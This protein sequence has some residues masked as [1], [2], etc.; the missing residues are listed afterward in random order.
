MFSR[1]RHSSTHSHA[2]RRSR[3]NPKQNGA[4][5]LVGAI[6]ERPFLSRCPVLLSVCAAVLT[7]MVC[8]AQ[9]RS[10]NG[11]STQGN[12]GGKPPSAGI[13]VSTTP[14][15]S[16]PSAFTTERGRTAG[17]TV[18]LDS[19]PTADVTINVTSS[20]T[21]E[22]NTDV[23]AL[24][25]TPTTWNIPQ[26]VIVIGADDM[27]ADGTVGYWIETEPASSEDPDYN[28]LNAADVSRSNIDDESPVTDA[29]YVRSFEMESRKKGP[30]TE[31]RLNIDVRHD[32]DA[33]GA[34]EESDFPAAG[35]VV[36]IAIYDSNGANVRNFVGTTSAQGAGTTAWYKLPGAGDYQIE[37]HDLSLTGFYWDPLDVLESS[38]GDEDWDGRPDVLLSN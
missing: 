35:V 3:W 5:L 29:I 21:T 33:N 13:S 12:K 11:M 8:C 38:L 22:G 28:G 31:I 17:F 14:T 16:L 34:S 4:P 23:P 15:F 36:V 25:F 20:D 37:V 9:L 19:Q 1:S 2:A 10:V 27:E 18:V 6:G 30:S 26:T 7:A 32:T 24:S